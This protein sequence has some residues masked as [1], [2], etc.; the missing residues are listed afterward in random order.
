MNDLICLG[1]EDGLI[2]L[3]SYQQSEVVALIKAHEKSVTS[4]ANFGNLLFSQSDK[5]LKVWQVDEH[6]L[7][8]THKLNGSVYLVC[9][10][11]CLY[12]GDSDG[13]I[14]MYP[15]KM[16]EKFEFGDFVLLFKA[17]HKISSL[18]RIDDLFIFTTNDSIYLARLQG[19]ELRVLEI[20]TLKGFK[21]F[22]IKSCDA[23]YYI[24]VG[25]SDMVQIYK[26][27]QVDNPTLLNTMMFS[28]EMNDIVLATDF[29]SV[30]CCG[31]GGL[32]WKFTYVPKDLIETFDKMDLGHVDQNSNF[33]D[34]TDD[35]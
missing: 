20:I 8:Y 25:F 35:E 18:R 6:K 16:K 17:P 23:Y 4:I 15:Y 21:C 11:N 1:S 13:S 26:W 34:D 32:L 7:I 24:V 2:Q 12:F 3:V 27:D 5:E 33:Q 14:K 9:E 10:Q 19:Q 31:M 29:K 28:M 30:I 22:D